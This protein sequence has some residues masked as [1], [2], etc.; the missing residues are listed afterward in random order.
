MNHNNNILDM[1]YRTPSIVPRISQI[2]LLCVEE[3]RMISLDQSIGDGIKLPINITLNLSY[4]R[5]WCFCWS[6]Y[7]C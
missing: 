3:G 1:I 6:I 4:T 7:V 2:N 5:W